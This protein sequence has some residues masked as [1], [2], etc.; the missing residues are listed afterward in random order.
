M[1]PSKNPRAQ[2]DAMLM[3]MKLN[4]QICKTLW[5]CGWSHPCLVTLR[6]QSGWAISSSILRY[7]LYRYWDSI[8]IFICNINIIS[9]FRNP[10]AIF[11]KPVTSAGQKP[12]DERRQI[13]GFTRRGERESKKPL[14]QIY[15]QPRSA[16][17]VL[18]WTECCIV[19]TCYIAL[20]SRI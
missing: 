4:L 3:L 7:P 15:S 13:I 10:I 17:N 6:P 8:F 19:A 5:A 12:R 16:C 1:W 14:S 20:L 18:Y 9:I 2:T 11:L